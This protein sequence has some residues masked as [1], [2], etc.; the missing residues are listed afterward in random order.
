VQFQAFD[1]TS[2]GVA[3][4]FNFT[5]GA[6]IPEPATLSLLGLALVGCLGFIRRR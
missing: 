5:Y 1:T 3:T 6:V 4:V 2:S